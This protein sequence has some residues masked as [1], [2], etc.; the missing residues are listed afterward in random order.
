MFYT[1]ESGDT[2]PRIA[3]KFY[4]DRTCWQTI[5]DANQ[6]VIVLVP[7]VVIF[8]PLY[9]CSGFQNKCEIIVV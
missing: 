8:I 6:D 4:G 3:E 2:L 9:S 1:V 7:G 5:Y